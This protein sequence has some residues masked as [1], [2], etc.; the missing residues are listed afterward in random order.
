[1]DFTPY[2]LIVSGITGVG[3]Q[4]QHAAYED[5]ASGTTR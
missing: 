2:A 1:M 3:R 4:P 5:T